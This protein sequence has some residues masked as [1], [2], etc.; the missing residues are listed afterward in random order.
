MLQ[1][2]VRI[3]AALFWGGKVEFCHFM[4]NRGRERQY[5]QSRGLVSQT[6]KFGRKKLDGKRQESRSLTNPEAQGKGNNVP[7]D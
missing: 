5:L 3:H 7:F 2:P 1:P 4:T 6:Y